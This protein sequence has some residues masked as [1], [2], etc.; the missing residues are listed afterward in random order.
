M[1]HR[2]FRPALLAVVAA[3]AVVASGIATPTV[4]AE[5]A[6][7]R[8]VARESSAWTPRPEQYPDTVK[9]T[10]IPITMDD[11]VVLR[12][13]LIQ[14]ADAHG[15][16]IDKRLPVIVT[17]TAYNKTAMSGGG[18]GLAGPPPSYL[19]KRGY[20]YLF[21]D[22]R[23]TGSSAGSWAAFSARENKD[24]G[25]VVAWAHRQPWSNGKVG[26][27]GPSYMGISQL[28]A[29]GH[30]PKGLK[31]IFPQVPGADVYRDV[32]ASGGQ[33]DVGFIPLWLGLVNGTALIPPAYTGSDP[34]SAIGNLLDHLIGGGS[35]TMTLALQAL[36][37]GNPMY[38]G[39]FYRQR[40]AI[41]YL[42]DVTVP[43]FL[44]GGQ[45]D[46]FQRGTPMI[47][48][49]LMRNGAPVKLI[50]GPWDHLQGSSGA[51][52]GDAGY[53]SIDEL[54]LRWFDSWI[55]GIDGHLDEI[56]PVTYYEQGA[57]RWVKKPRWIAD[58]LHARSYA[59]SGSS[60][61]G[62]RA[63]ELRL[64]DPKAGT[65]TLVPLPVSG[66]CTRSANQWT[67]GVL[68]MV[69]A[70]NPCFTNNDINDYTG[71]TFQTAPVDRAVRM[72]GPINAHLFVSTTGGDG[73]LSVVVEDVAP[74]G[75]VHRI[76]GGWQVVSQRKLIKDR[77][78]YLDGQLIQ[79]WHPFTKE[80]KAKLKAG[81]IAPVDVEIFPTGAVIAEG[82]RLRL[83]IQGYDVPH[84]LAPIPDLPSQAL[85]LKI[86]TG[87]G[88]RSV[89]TLPV[90]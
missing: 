77:S 55:K 38:D 9:T 84:L 22:A 49:K 3:S 34:Q 59:L 31:A 73:M 28:M 8:A 52:V 61:M 47:F 50:E 7:V 19:V 18:G 48:E 87:P 58:D 29:A 26:M 72:Q 33:L 78:R 68:S 89:V 13:D 23:G 37:G 64:K 14:P 25:K 11:G 70:D 21:V 69:W 27:A 54:Q 85:P 1:N 60:A 6:P 2:L 65:S 71:L 53:G 15:E 82:H 10:D 12:G 46:L 45:Y 66:L 74:D 5:A 35:F 17:I 62:G 32:V 67:A 81:T 80:S 43:T 75:T 83:T 20:N 86:Y 90:R 63:G 41:N 44:I 4:G 79:P 40:S 39:P 51:D 24:S 42:D 16:A 36:L 88:H 57:D 76:T 56:A 30:H